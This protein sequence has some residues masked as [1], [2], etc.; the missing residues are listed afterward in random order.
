MPNA[1]QIVFE[2][3]LQLDTGNLSLSL[4]HVEILASTYLYIYT[5][6]HIYMTRVRMMMSAGDTCQSIYIARTGNLHGSILYLPAK[7]VLVEKGQ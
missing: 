3:K 1:C 5:E 7:H 6:A 2:V 4:S